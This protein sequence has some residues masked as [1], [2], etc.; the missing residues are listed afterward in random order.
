MGIV[1]LVG[2]WLCVAR[3]WIVDGPRIPMMF[4]GIWALGGIGIPAIGLSPSLF[5]TL[6]GILGVIMLFI[7]QNKK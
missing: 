4:I 7:A 2:F 5:W 1:V 6:Q 3:L